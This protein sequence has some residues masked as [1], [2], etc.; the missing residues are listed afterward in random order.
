MDIIVGSTAKIDDIEMAKVAEDSGISH[1]GIGQGPLITSDP[2]QYMALATQVTTELKIGPYVMDPVTRIAPSIA[3]SLATLEELAPNRIFCGMGTA[4]NAMH[5]MGRKSAS[6]KELAEAMGIIKA[7]VH[8]ERAMHDWRGEERAVELLAV[9]D[10]TLR[11]AEH[12]P[13]YVAAGGPKGLRNAARYADALIYCVGPNPNM[14]AMVRK[15]L[16]RLVEEEGRSP[17]SVKLIGLTW[18]YESQPGETWEDALSKGF[19]T[20]APMGSTITD[21][22]FLKLH[23]EEIGVDIVDK[24]I[25]AAMALM[26]APE[27]VGATDHLDQWKNY[28][29]GYDPRH[30]KL[31]SKELLDFWCLYGSR[32]EIRDNAQLM[33]DSGL[34]GLSF[35]LYNPTETHRDIANIG[36]ALLS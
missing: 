20:T 33:M 11:V 6:P 18:F 28:A 30:S 9:G 19:G 13:M 29:K 1:L 3:N 21:M 17:G 14:I 27:E 16:D 10:G 24:S 31:M 32:S 4:N 22:G 35:F 23:R 26:G 2:F 5:S 8:G 36:R 12:M 25:N 34:D 7:M 15:E